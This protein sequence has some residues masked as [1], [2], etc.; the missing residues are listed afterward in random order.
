MKIKRLHLWMLP[1]VALSLSLALP[2]DAHNGAVAL[3]VPLEGITVDGDLSDWPQGLR[4]YAITRPEFGVEP[5]DDADF[6]AFFRIGFNAAENALYLGV[7]VEDQSAVVSP[8]VDSSWDNQDGCEIYLDWAHGQQDFAPQF[9]FYGEH[10]EEFGVEGL[11]EHIVVKFKRGKGWHRYE[12]RLD[13][14]GLSAGKVELAANS[15][16]GIDVVTGDKDEDGSFSWMAWGGGIAKTR[17][18]ERRGD[19]LLLQ[20][21]ADVASAVGRVTV[22]GS[23]AA[24]G[25]LAIA[26]YR[27]GHPIGGAHTDEEG[28][29]EAL[30]LPGEYTFKPG[31]RQG[32]K[33]FEFGGLV[34]SAG[35]VLEADF[36][37]VPMPYL[38]RLAIKVGSRHQQDFATA[39]AAEIE[40]LLLK[41][42]LSKTHL[43]VPN[44]P[45][46]VLSLFF[47]MKTLEE[48]QQKRAALEGDST[49][50]AA[51]RQVG[52]G[53]GITW[54]EGQP[55]YD[56]EFISV[57]AGTGTIKVA[58]KGRKVKAGLGVKVPAG[59]DPSAGW[60]DWTE[61]VAGAEV[62]ALLR[63]GQ[64]HL[65]IGSNGRG[66]GYYDGEG[67]TS[68]S[69]EDGLPHDWVRA[70]AQDGQ[71]HLWIGT[72]G[73][74]LSRFDGEHFTT[75]TTEDGL[76]SNVVSALLIDKAGALWIGTE[77][78]GVSRFDGQQFT[79]FTVRDG[80]GNDWVSALL[81][82]G[83]GAIWIGTEG[84]GI[85]RYDGQRFS[86]FNSRDGLGHD[87][88]GS[89][90]QDGSGALWVGTLAGVSRYDGSRFT[91]YT[92]QDGLGHDWVGA[93]LQDGPDAIWIGTAGGGLCR[94]DGKAFTEI[95]HGERA[96]VSALAPGTEGGIWVGT[97]GGLSL[98]R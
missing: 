23:A 86:I 46:G 85:S 12:W 7:E 10:L 80:L 94:Y 13:L 63:D 87:W 39:F 88:I 50:T 2:A 57:P 16:L 19:L 64:G 81:Q 70:L 74:G 33:P 65:W 11:L 58:G 75:F 77:G 93:L 47:E 60:Q 43:P 31:P 41:H 30:L 20:T 25:G 44:V 5:K 49:W 68:F 90:L 21:Y 78:G 24:Y 96:A 28:R 82:D 35:K 48:M 89:F 61:G 51:L 84:G 91:T 9:A 59:A 42:G 8:L 26:M 6:S 71:G 3:A 66:L 97:E 52:K 18:P 95:A 54:P 34:L 27:D 17:G 73:G 83:K 72:D 36:S 53:Q 22:E 38:G 15:M 4:H 14:A 40:P 69:R 37:V 79:G 45:D 29:Y 92:T 67:F 56:L 76:P 32:I 55:L 98:Y 1:M 62:R